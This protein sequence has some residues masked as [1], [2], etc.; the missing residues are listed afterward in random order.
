MIFNATVGIFIPDSKYFILFSLKKSFFKLLFFNKNKILTF[1]VCFYKTVNQYFKY[2]KPFAIAKLSINKH[3]L[4]FLDGVLMSRTFV[5]LIVTNETTQVIKD[6]RSETFHEIIYGK[7]PRRK[8][9]PRFF[10]SQ[11]C[12]VVYGIIE[13]S[14]ATA[15]TSIDFFPIPQ[16]GFKCQLTRNPWFFKDS[17]CFM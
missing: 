9:A 13:V 4:L 2:N 8:R 7:P 1:K 15:L 17:T 5:L 14:L 16:P 12:A 3:V 11:N 10:L 6:H